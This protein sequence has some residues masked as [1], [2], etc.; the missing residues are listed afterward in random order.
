MPGSTDDE[1]VRRGLRD[2]DVILLQKP[3]TADR[4]ACAV[5]AAL[6]PVG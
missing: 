1:I 2:A 5:R 6:A 3:F 4:L